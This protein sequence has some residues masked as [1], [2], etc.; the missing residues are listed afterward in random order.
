MV[1]GLVIAVSSVSAWAMLEDY[2][3]GGSRVTMKFTN[4]EVST[5]YNNLVTNTTYT[6]AA[7]DALPWSDPGGGA[8]WRSAAA[9]AAV[10]GSGNP[11]EDLWGIFT[12]K[13]IAATDTDA[14]LWSRDWGVADPR[15]GANPAFEVTGMFWGERDKSV[16]WDGGSLLVQGDNV[17][18]A[19]FE[20]TARNFSFAGGPG[21]AGSR[22]G[23]DP[24]YPGATDGTLIFTGNSVAGDPDASPF[25]FF[26]SYT[27]SPSP[28]GKGSFLGNTG[29]VPYWGTGSLNQLITN[30][31]PGIDFKFQFTAD[32]GT[33]GWLLKSEDPIKTEITPELSSTALLFLGMLPVGLISRRRRK[34]S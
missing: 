15:W 3:P 8:P 22:S 17:Q 25:E 33:N 21:V 4:W 32:D 16:T 31:I 19:F 6:G 18:F 26:A 30:V 7:L 2:L 9:G 29:T 5:L 14:L 11:T 12:L 23:G 13:S 24:V 34:R 10:D 1:I 20:D 27:P 28:T